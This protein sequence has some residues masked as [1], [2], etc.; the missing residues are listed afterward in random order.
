MALFSSPRSLD[1]TRSTA[2]G[3]IR[4]ALAQPMAN[5]YLVVVSAGLLIGLG[6]LMVL[7]ASSVH[8]EVAYGDSYYIVKRQLMFLLAGLAG[9]GVILRLKPATLRAF[10]WPLL[11]LSAV[12]LILTFTPLGVEVA[13]NRNWVQFGTPWLRFQPSEFAKLAIVLWGADNLARKQ[14]ILDRPRELVPFLGFSA[15]LVLLVMLQRDLGTAII[16]GGIIVVVL[17]LT[18]A[19]L[20]VLGLVL[21]LAMAAATAMV[22][23]SPNRMNRVLG[24]LNPTADTDGVN[25]QP[26]RAIYSLASGG[27]WG[28]GLGQSKQKWGMLV[29]AHTDFV[30]AIIGEEMGLVGTLSVIALFTTLVWAAFRIGRRCP[31]PFIRNLA[32]GVGAW[33][34]VQSVLNMA[35]VMRLLPVIGV[36]LPLV[37]YGGSS[38]LANLAALGLLAVCARQEPAARRAAARRDRKP[39]ARV[40]AVV[41]GRRG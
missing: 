2:T 24:Y 27:W 37:S 19:P 12:A 29:E 34:M 3:L 31:D 33:F 38:L 5:F 17:F 9:V 21:S 4:H 15:I 35:V 23:V 32:V 6:T 40:T 41:D 18:G 30:F 16:M 14:K 13:G 10:A 8:A 1:Q 22:V 25:Q 28:V 39:A 7:S 26:M 20:R 36:T 11:L